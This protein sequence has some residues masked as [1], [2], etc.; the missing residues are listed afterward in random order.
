MAVS[1]GP[2]SLALVALAKLFN[3]ETK[4]KIYYVLIDHNLRKNS[5]TEANS[6]KRLLKKN[7]INLL[8]IKN[9]KKKD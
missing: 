9:K 5:S 8:I 2:D 4:C 6:V 7:K 1:G 3:Y